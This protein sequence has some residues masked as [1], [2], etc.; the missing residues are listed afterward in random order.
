M[1]DRA[2][3]HA[4]S[5]LNGANTQEFYDTT[6]HERVFAFAPIFYQDDFMGAGHAAAFP[7][8]ATVGSDWIKKTVQ[9]SGSPSVA[10]VA[11]AA[12]GQ[13]ELL[14]D[15]TSEKQEATL[16]W[17]DKLELDVTKGFVFEARVKFV[18]LPS[19]SG[20][21]AV[22]GVSSAWIDGPDN[23]SEYLE[24]GASGSGVIN[25]RSQDGTTQNAIA[26][27]FTADTTTFH[28]YR[29]DATVL[30]NI[31]YFIDGAEQNTDNQLAFGATGTSAI[32]QPYLSCY[33]P[34]GAGNAA[35]EVDYVRFFA[36]QRD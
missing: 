10:A 26:T 34:S 13:V 6:T 7:T 2:R 19:A 14:I 33:K 27:G 22:F 21:E 30:T 24:F 11:N 8:T 9:T 12:F 15:T 36:A 28:I 20:V 31:R 17:A 16:Y 35:F 3:V 32:L 23:A 25:M 29:I 1:S 4:I 18:T 5:P